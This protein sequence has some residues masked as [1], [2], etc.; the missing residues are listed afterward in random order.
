MGSNTERILREVSE[1]SERV[2][3]EQVRKLRP[4][5]LAFQRSANAAAIELEGRNAARKCISD[6]SRGHRI[7]NAQYDNPKEPRKGDINLDEKTVCDH[8]LRHGGGRP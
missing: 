5:F 3:C 1:S 6:V 2:L 4:G 8:G 7:A